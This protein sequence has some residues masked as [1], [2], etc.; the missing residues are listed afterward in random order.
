MNAGIASSAD[1]STTGEASSNPTPD[2]P[3]EPE[4]DGFVEISNLFQNNAEKRRYGVAITDIDGDQDFEAVITGYGSANEV[5]D[6]VDGVYVDVAP[7]GL[8]TQ[9]T[10]HWGSRM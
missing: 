5:W 8:E 10:G 9:Q 6:F 7:E 4:V 2:E 1:G 3:T